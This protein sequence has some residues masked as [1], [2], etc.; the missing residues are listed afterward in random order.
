MVALVYLSQPAGWRYLAGQAFKPGLI[1]SVESAGTNSYYIG[2]PPHPLSQKVA[3]MHGID[4]SQPRARRFIAEDFEAYDK[5]MRWRKMY[6]MIF[7][8]FPNISLMD[9]KLT[10]WCM[11]HTL[12]Q[13]R[14]TRSILWAWGGLYW[15]LSFTWR[16]LWC[17][18]KKYS[19]FHPHIQFSI[20]IIHGK[21]IF[22]T[23]H[24][25]FRT[26]GCS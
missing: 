2:E 1:W 6:W 3:R 5:F 15:S 4:I 20:A 13:T 14:C 9:H 21:T 24:K 19:I 23:R 12:A 8:V 25:R 26:R 7:A 16:S 22:T 10:C 17:Y 18:I 11:K